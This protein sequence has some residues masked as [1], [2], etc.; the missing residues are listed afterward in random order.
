VDGSPPVVSL[1]RTDDEL[2]ATRPHELLG[3]RANPTGVDFAH[4]AMA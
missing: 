3:A 1:T 2:D 4:E